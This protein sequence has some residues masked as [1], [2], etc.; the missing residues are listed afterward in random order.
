MSFQTVGGGGAERVKRVQPAAGGG[1]GLPD[2]HNK[3]EITDCHHN[4]IPLNLLKQ[5]LKL[6][7][8]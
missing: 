6:C 5:F 4:I 8:K 7:R 3:S 1:D 2:L